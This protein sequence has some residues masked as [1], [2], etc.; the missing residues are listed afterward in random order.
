MK[1]ASLQHGKILT[2]DVAPF[3]GVKIE[4][5]PPN[6]QE[7]MLTRVGDLC[8]LIVPGQAEPLVVDA[9]DQKNRRDLQR[10]VEQDGPR[11]CWLVGVRSELNQVIA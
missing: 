8:A 1:I 11:L 10:S 3:V 7:L 5:V 9:W 2:L 4:R 6:G